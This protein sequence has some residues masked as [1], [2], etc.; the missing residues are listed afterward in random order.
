MSSCRLVE[1]D[2]ERPEDTE[3]KSGQRQ[4]RSADRQSPERHA[5]HRTAASLRILMDV[6]VGHMVVGEE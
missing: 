5:E 6:A 1:L 4:E 3:Q 2:D